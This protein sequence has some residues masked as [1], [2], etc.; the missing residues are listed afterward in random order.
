MQGQP[1]R[2]Q[3]FYPIVERQ[4]TRNQYLLAEKVAVYGVAALLAAATYFG[5]APKIFSADPTGPISPLATGQ[6]ANEIFLAAVFLVAGLVLAAG[7][8]FVRPASFSLVLLAGMAGISMKSGMFRVLVWQDGTGVAVWGRMLAELLVLAIVMLVADF[9]AAY[10]RRW[11]AGRRGGFVIL[12]ATL[13]DEQLADLVEEKIVLPERQLL[14]SR[15]VLL[16]M[17]RENH[18]LA[19]LLLLGRLKKL[20]SSHR[21][22]AVMA[23]KNAAGF[24][25]VGTAIGLVAAYVLAGSACRGQ[26]VFAAFAAFWLASVAAYHMYPVTDSFPAWI[27]PVIVGAVYF[28]IAMFTSSAINPDQWEKLRNVF[29]ILPVDWIFAG[30]AGAMFGL[31]SS[32]RAKETQIIEKLD[33]EEQKG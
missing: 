6:Y 23:L 21:T 19:L 26:L 32:D 22:L 3:I 15:E 24:L 27:M 18:A 5:F 14:W 11:I 12:S 8:V 1:D 9:A 2:I 4:M 28:L 13:N 20:Q 10:F 30:G 7:G 25:F 31:W 16:E 33:L 17:S 29:Q